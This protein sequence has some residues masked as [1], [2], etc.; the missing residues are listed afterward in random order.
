VQ[1]ALPHASSRSASVGPSVRVP[2]ESTE[3]DARGRTDRRASLDL[4]EASDNLA[5]AREP[6]DKRDVT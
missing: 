4:T 2:D 5:E 6:L 3:G 1:N